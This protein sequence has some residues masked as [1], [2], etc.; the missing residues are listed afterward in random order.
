MKKIQ[1]LIENRLNRKNTL[2]DATSK[3]TFPLNQLI[4]GRAQVAQV[5]PAAKNLG[6]LSKK[7]YPRANIF[8]K[9]EQEQQHLRAVQTVLKRQPMVVSQESRTSELEIRRQSTVE[10]DVKN[11]IS[12]LSGLGPRSN[13]MHGWSQSHLPEEDTKSKSPLLSTNVPFK[14]IGGLNQTALQ[15]ENLEQE[16]FQNT[17]TNR[18]NVE[19]AIS[20]GEPAALSQNL[21]V[22]KLESQPTGILSFSQISHSSKKDVRQFQ[23]QTQGNVKYFDR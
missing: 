22:K 4:N 14:K 18:S 3:R 15:T 9:E 10:D 21:N 6:K 11:D 20:R 13:E 5:E 17:F 7:I 12:M 19:Q 16:D 8:K 1:N 23:A 2:V